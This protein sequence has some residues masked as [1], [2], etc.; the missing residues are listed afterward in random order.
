M[1]TSICTCKCKLEFRLFKWISKKIFLPVF[2]HEY[3]C[4][5]H[6]VIIGKFKKFCGHGVH[7]YTVHVHIVA[8]VTRKF[9]KYFSNVCT[10]IFLGKVARDWFMMEINK[11][12]V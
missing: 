9:L 4:Y 10:I 11:F 12:G 5:L 2:L 1:F 8:C 6:I 3:H 7:E